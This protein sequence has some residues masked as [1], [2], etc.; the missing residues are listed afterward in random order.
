L[1]QKNPNDNE[2][3]GL[4]VGVLMRLDLSDDYIDKVKKVKSLGDLAV[5][6]CEEIVNSISFNDPDKRL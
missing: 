1:S 2:L 4:L 6:I 3:L 5:P